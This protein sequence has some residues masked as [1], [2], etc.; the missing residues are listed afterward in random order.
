MVYIVCFDV[1][2]FLKF[3]RYLREV[4]NLM[5]AILLFIWLTYVTE[6]KSRYNDMNKESH[7]PSGYST[8]SSIL[9]HFINLQ[10]HLML[11]IQN[12]WKQ[13]IDI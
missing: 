3:D 10:Y 11:K 7:S 2:R 9:R 4:I 12:R 13:T 5:L 1:F 8:N 6:D